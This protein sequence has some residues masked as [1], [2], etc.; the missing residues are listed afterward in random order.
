MNPPSHLTMLRWASI[1]WRCCPAPPYPHLAMLATLCLSIT[2]VAMLF[3]DVVA[4]LAKVANS[5]GSLERQDRQGRQHRNIAELAV[6][7]AR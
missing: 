5:T 3:G 6:A 2:Y 1:G 7:D 4:M